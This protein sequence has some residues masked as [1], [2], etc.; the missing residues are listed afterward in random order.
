MNGILLI[1]KP[2]GI[3]SHAVISKLRKKLGT[4]KI[5][6]AG[7]LDPSATGLL[8]ICVGNAT[9]ISG[10]IMDLDKG[11]QTDFTLGK[12]TTTY[13]SEGEIVSEKNASHIAEQNILEKLP[14]LTGLIA[15]KPPIYS[16]IKIKGKKLYQYA[17][18]NTEVE[19]PTRNVTIHSLT[20][21][22]FSSPKASLNIQCTKGTYVRSIVHDLGESLGVGASV[23][24]IH[25]TYSAPFHV[26]DATPLSVLLEMDL[27][28]IQQK[29]I[30]IAQALQGKFHMIPVSSDEEASIRR[31]VEYT[32]DNVRD[33]VHSPDDLFLFVSQDDGHEIAIAKW[34]EKKNI[35]YLRIL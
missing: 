4:K 34:G 31:G 6:H 18:S 16:A 33:S 35:S 15:Q 23:D 12:T 10:Y 5:G 20:L 3:T 2:V 30:T 28:D 11:Y 1:D 13:D 8:V 24:I 27:K 29:M 19:I 26:K 22:Q 21:T 9:K 14:S 25:R 32:K 17:R 7:T